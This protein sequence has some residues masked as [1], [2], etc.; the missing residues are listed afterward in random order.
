MLGHDY[1]SHGYYF[2]TICT[3][4]RQRL[5]GE[6]VRDEMRLSHAGMMLCDAI[7]TIDSRYEFVSVDCSIV[8][9]NHV[10]LLVGMGIRLSDEQSSESVGDVV[11]WFKNSSVRR[12]GIGVREQGWPPFAGRLWQ[13][14]FHDHIV[15]NENELETLRQY[16][17]NN[18]YMW[19]KD[20]FY[21]W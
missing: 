3:D 9:P 15:R 2:L 14:S 8:M 7:Q 21:D 17:A 1:S 11:R 16:I 10:H 6:I 4:K 12:Y 19:D 20:K 18:V 13:K 5:F